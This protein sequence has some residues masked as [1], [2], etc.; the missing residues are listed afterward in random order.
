MRQTGFFIADSLRGLRLWRVW[1][2]LAINDLRGRFARS[3]L[4]FAWILVSFAIWAAGVGL[5]YA[6]LFSLDAKTFVPFLTI[7]FALWGFIS[8]SFVESSNALINS[9]GYVKQ[10]NLPKQTYIFRSMLSQTITLAMSL[11]VCFIIIGLFGA[12]SVN[13]VLYALPG[14][15]LLLVA[16]TLHAFISAYITPYVRDFPHAVGS[17]LNVLFFVTPIIFPAEMLAKKGLGTIF[18]Y[19][20]FYYLLEVVR[21]PLLQGTMP[22]ANIWLG[23]GSY[24]VFMAILVW[25]V[26]RTLD[27]RLVYAL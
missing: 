25:I 20:P 10:F 7:G 16:A 6:R 19:N 9:S 15:L 13:G 23:A 11:S 17:L 4:G 24:V 8:N 3:M 14:L 5:I 22:A 21:E 27:K 12:L 18:V 26:C 2:Y 1:G